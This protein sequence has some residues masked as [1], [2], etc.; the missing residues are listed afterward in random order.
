MKISPWQSAGA[1][2]MAITI[3]RLLLIL[4][5]GEKKNNKNKAV[6]GTQNPQCMQNLGKF[7]ESRDFCH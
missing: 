6:F 3:P 5:S 4:P 2:T 1:Q 7:K